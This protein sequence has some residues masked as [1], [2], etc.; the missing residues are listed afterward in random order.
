M[1]NLTMITE[2]IAAGFEKA[3]IEKP[4][5]MELTGASWT[6][7]GTITAICFA[8]VGLILWAVD[9]IRKE[10]QTPTLS[11]LCT[12]AVFQ[13]KVATSHLEPEEARRAAARRAEGL[14]VVINREVDQFLAREREGGRLVGW[15][16][17]VGR[18]WKKWRRGRRRRAC[19]SFN[20]LSWIVKIFLNFLASIKEKM[21]QNTLT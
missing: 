7:I 16:E 11:D 21:E 15:V 5:R 3:D 6:A 9:T 8:F 12:A 20:P 18:G 4:L 2:A 10:K 19:G 1:D 14:V 17:W 13:Q